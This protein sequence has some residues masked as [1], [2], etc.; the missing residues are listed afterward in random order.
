MMQLVRLMKD[1]ETCAAR[2]THM[3]QTPH[4]E[5]HFTASEMVRDIVIGMT[6]RFLGPVGAVAFYGVGTLLVTGVWAWL[7]P[8]LRRADRLA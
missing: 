5:K 3:P 8:S 6:A 1:K 7:F 4:T 2:G